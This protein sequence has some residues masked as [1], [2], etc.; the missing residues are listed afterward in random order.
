LKPIG[1]LEFFFHGK[2][3]ILMQQISDFVKI[4]R[5]IL[6]WLTEA[7]CPM[8]MM[9]VVVV[10]VVVLNIHQNQRGETTDGRTHLQGT[11]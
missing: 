7:E 3:K 10:V 6:H 2:K 9:M 5:A 11:N 8:M 4:S 1:T